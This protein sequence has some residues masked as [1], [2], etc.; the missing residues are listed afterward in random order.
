MLAARNCHNNV[1]QLLIEHGADVND[2]IYCDKPTGY[3]CGLTALH[4]AV[5]CK[6]VQGAHLLIT[7][8]AK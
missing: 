4:A 6:D 2:R 5:F 8:G 1:L 7:H 3:W